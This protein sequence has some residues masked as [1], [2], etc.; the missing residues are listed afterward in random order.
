M[1]K[2]ISYQ[3][4]DD[5]IEAKARWFQSLT[6]EERIQWLNETVEAALAAN[7]DL[8]NQP[9]DFPANWRV[10]VIALPEGPY[11]RQGPP[12]KPR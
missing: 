8:A 10:R 9:D 4:T 5:S 6:V 1:K 11:V 2:A 7:P 3:G 12:G